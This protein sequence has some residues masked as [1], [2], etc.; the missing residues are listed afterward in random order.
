MKSVRLVLGEVWRNH[1]RI[2]RLAQ[3]E[4]RAKNAGTAMGT[5]WDFF[6]P[7]FQILVYWF[8]FD[9]GMKSN[10]AD[11][12]PYVAWMIA[13]MVP[14]FTMSNVM[15]ASA[16]CI[17]ANA[18]I[19]RN[20]AIPLSIIPAKTVVIH[21][22]EQ[23]WMLLIML[24]MLLSYGIFPNLYW[25]QL[26][27]YFFAMTVFLF[28]FT[29]LS[30]AFGAAVEDFGR[31]LSP[32]IRLMFYLS[33]VIIDLNAMPAKLQWLLKLNPATY[34]VMG[35][36]N[37][38]LYHIGIWE[39]PWHALSFWSVTLLLLFFGCALHIRLRDRFV[40]ML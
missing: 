39:S 25:L 16:G 11:K 3:Y 12:L 15:M 38:F 37:T 23:G 29:L 27:Y 13:G 2:F 8:V 32:V 28:A 6:T 33:Y 18:A 40:D 30:S 21:L 35:Y 31:F 24:V 36:R 17:S 4:Q 26:I 14:W 34:I 5:L 19:I 20:V 7:L 1:D 9:V 22:F 10:R